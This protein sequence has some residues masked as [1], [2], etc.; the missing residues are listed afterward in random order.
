MV[1]FAGESGNNQKDMGVNDFPLRFYSDVWSGWG[2]WLG[3]KSGRGE[4]SSDSLHLIP[5][6]QTIHSDTPIG[7]G[8]ER[9]WYTSAGIGRGRGVCQ[10]NCGTPEP[11]NYRIQ[12]R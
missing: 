8:G 4:A 5:S 7:I 6:Q 12:L 2:P 10:E 1:G 3:V 11:K 9:G